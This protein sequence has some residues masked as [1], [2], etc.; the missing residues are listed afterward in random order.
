MAL[1]WPTSGTQLLYFTDLSKLTL[2]HRT[3]VPGSG[4]LGTM[5]PG[6]SQVGTIYPGH[7]TFLVPS[8]PVTVPGI[9]HNHVSF[10]AGTSSHL[11]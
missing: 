4:T 2:G 8:T 11:H 1:D 3:L 7:R 9:S 6:S 10:C 5:L